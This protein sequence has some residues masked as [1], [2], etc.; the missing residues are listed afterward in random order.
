MKRLKHRVAFRNVLSCCTD[1]GVDDR[2]SHTSHLLFLVALDDVLELLLEVGNSSVRLV[3]VYVARRTGE[4]LSKPE[5]IRCLKRYLAR[6]IFQALRA[7]YA[8]L[9]MAT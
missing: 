3:N 1:H 4:G 9:A 6:E 5:I 8:V 7:D 2:E